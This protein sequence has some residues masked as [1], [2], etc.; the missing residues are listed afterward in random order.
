MATRFLSSSGDFDLWNIAKLQ[1]GVLK[2][3][4]NN[5]DWAEKNT[6]FCREN[7]GKLFSFHLWLGIGK[8]GLSLPSATTLGHC[9][10]QISSKSWEPVQ[11]LPE[12]GLHSQ[13]RGDVTWNLSE[14]CHRDDQE[15]SRG[16]SAIPRIAR[17]WQFSAGPCGMSRGM[18]TPCLID[19]AWLPTM[20]GTRSS[21]YQK[22]T[23]WLINQLRDLGITRESEDLI[24][25]IK[26]NKLYSPNPPVAP[27]SKVP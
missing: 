2:E 11:I 4:E 18:P 12:N 27:P 6:F 9:T 5:L 1:R 19:F 3:W 17:I 8:T 7:L 13:M 26:V 24:V 23:A 22:G 21:G 16:C 25:L 10:D 14:N 20:K 15:R